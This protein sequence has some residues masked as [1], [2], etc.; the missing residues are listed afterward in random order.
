L[1]STVETSLAVIIPTFNR[2]HT[3][4]RAI[5]SVLASPRT[6]I[7]LAVVDDCSSDGTP[8]LLA[9]MSDS[10]LTVLRMST[11]GRANLARNRGARSTRAPILAFLDSDDEFLPGRVERLIHFFAGNPNV[12]AVLD[13]FH[14]SDGR[15]RRLF[16][17]PPVTA[18]G[19]GL[20][21]LLV[22]HALPLTNS[23]V[24]MRRSVF[25]D[26]GG[27]DPELRR[28][29]DRDIL[30]RLAR[31]HAVAI[32]TAADVVKHQSP[33]SFSRRAAGYVSGLDDL[34][35]RHDA[36]LAPEHRDILGYLVARVILR[37]AAAGRLVSTVSVLRAISTASHLPFGT[38]TAL[39][40]YRSGRRI[41]KRAEQ[42]V[43]GVISESRPCYPANA[44]ASEASGRKAE[45][46]LG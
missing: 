29:Q 36:F 18:T 21:N 35:A 3:I 25:E 7:E 9:S 2:A 34:V 10:R 12:H 43:H 4:R 23:V 20:V 30:L 28:H 14:V 39:T 42:S 11:S 46:L 33:D 38:L 41:R 13:G 16:A 15:S 6:D 40:R 45:S 22:C 19:T 1:Q 31:R 5:G 8:E 24:A 37:E 27:F 32:G 26:I 44:G 17:H